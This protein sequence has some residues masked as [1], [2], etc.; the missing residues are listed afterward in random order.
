VVLV[1]QHAMHMCH[2]I[3]SSVTC[4][5]LPY[6]FPNCLIYG[7]IFGEKLLNIKCVLILY[8]AFVLQAGMKVKYIRCFNNP[9][10]NMNI[11]MGETNFPEAICNDLQNQV[12]IN[13]IFNIYKLYQTYI[14]VRI[15]K[16]FEFLY[17]KYED[18]I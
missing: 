1:T 17:H 12:P 7:T 4:L 8:T 5:F 13:N 18:Y 9:R 16:H 14:Y 3:L 11:N 6:F 15:K 2:I 10:I